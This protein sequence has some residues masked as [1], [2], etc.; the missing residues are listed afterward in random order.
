MK[1][2]LL[3]A[4]IFFFV[5][6]LCCQFEISAGYAVNKNL[7]DGLPLHIGYDIKIKDRLFTKP[8]LGYK[9][10]YHFN[11]F[12]GATI[13]VS[14][15]EIHQTLSYEIFKRKNFTLKP[16]FGVNYRFYRWKGKMKPPLNELPIRAW[17]IEFRD[18]EFLRL[19][20][21]DD[22]SEDKYS[23]SNFGFS[24]QLQAQ[25]KLSEKIWLHLT[26]FLEPD[27]DGSQNT[28]GC[29]AGI[30]FKNQ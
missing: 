9:Y 17:A 18:R 6:K 7:A 19:V 15:F 5:S 30:V 10:L 16:N 23:V 20:N 26:P 4:F 25:L 12:V 22:G 2:L 13:K 27:Y 11:D 21:S 8:Q 29:Y 24:F 3:T 1:I 14:I 28:G